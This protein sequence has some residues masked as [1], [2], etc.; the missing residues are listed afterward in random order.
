MLELQF[1]EGMASVGCSHRLFSWKRFSEEG[2][3]AGLA[4]V[5]CPFINDCKSNGAK[6]ILSKGEIIRRLDAEVAVPGHK[7][8]F[9]TNRELSE[10]LKGGARREYR[11]FDDDKVCH[12]WQYHDEYKDSSVGGIVFVRD[13]DEPWHVAVVKE[14][15]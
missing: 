8:R 12:D 7:E 11:K 2:D 13:G 1:Y 14:V 5:I 9:M 10:W 4:C 3:C 15:R 6:S